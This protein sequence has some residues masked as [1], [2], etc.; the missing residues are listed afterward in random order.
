[1]RGTVC[2][3]LSVVLFCLIVFGA[4]QPPARPCVPPPSSAWWGLFCPALFQLDGSAE[5]R[6]SV[7]FS[8]PLLRRLRGL[9]RL[10]A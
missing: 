4:S 3:L 1:M 9:F 5:E 8:W 2:M 10:S 6:D 7:T